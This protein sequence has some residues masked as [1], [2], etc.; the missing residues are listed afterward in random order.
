MISTP[1]MEN[2][3]VITVSGLW[4]VKSS[5]QEEWI[6]LDTR[7]RSIQRVRYDLG[8]EEGLTISQARTSKQ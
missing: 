2:A 5:K 8:L 3:G 4:M 6:C 1:L 7:T